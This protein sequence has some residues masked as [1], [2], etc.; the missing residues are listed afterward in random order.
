MNTPRI[1]FPTGLPT[2]VN[3][4]AYYMEFRPNLWQRICWWDRWPWRPRAITLED[5]I[6]GKQPYLVTVRENGVLIGWHP[7]DSAEVGTTVVVGRWSAL[8]G[9]F[10]PRKYEVI[11]GRDPEWRDPEWRE[12]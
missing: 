7:V 10:S 9:I 3:G 11:V 12:M 4:G 8:A 6:W 2:P 1:Y 5:R